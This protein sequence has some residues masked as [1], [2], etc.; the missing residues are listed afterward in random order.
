MRK[1]DKIIVLY[2]TY[3]VVHGKSIIDTI[4]INKYPTEKYENMKRFCLG[5]SSVTSEYGGYYK[6][7]NVNYKNGT[8]D[9]KEYNDWNDASYWIMTLYLNKSYK[10]GDRYIYDID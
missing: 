4:Y 9:I 8:V 2:V 10:K 1:G 7:I 6:D 5:D 3:H